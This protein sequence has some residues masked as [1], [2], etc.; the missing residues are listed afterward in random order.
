MIILA[1]TIGIVISALGILFLVLP[2]KAKLI[3]NFWKQGS[4]IYGA[5]ILRVLFSVVLFLAAS[6]SR[7]PVITAILGLMFMVS[8]I[9]VFVMGVEKSKELIQWW[10][11]QPSLIHRLLGLLVLCFG[12]LVLYTV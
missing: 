10:E 12:L 11:D 6:Q 5:G 1:K 4:R 9:L 3:M 8:G 2:E 7:A